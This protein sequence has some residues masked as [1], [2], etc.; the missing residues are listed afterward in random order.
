M[1]NIP[2]HDHAEFRAALDAKHIPANQQDHFLRWLRFYL[3]FCSKYGFEPYDPQSLPHFIKK[4]QS[5]NQGPFQQQ[6]ATEAV[7]IFLEISSAENTNPNE[8]PHGNFSGDRK[9]TRLN[10]S[11]YS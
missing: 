10:S 6:Q 2:A 7:H 1:K 4:L 9:S 3:D 11:H 8:N 5:K